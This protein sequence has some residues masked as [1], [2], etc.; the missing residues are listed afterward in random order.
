[1]TTVALDESLI[2]RTKRRTTEVGLTPEQCIAINLFWRKGVRAAI[3]AKVFQVS[4]NTI[5]YRCLTGTRPSYPASAD[6]STAR[7]TNSVIDGLGET[8]AWQKF[9][10]D[11]MVRAVNAE[12][13]AEAVRRTEQTRGVNP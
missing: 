2:F 13:A 8:A 6:T 4:K 9:V 3:L 5:Y 12:M 1:M 11:E 10:P 7:Q